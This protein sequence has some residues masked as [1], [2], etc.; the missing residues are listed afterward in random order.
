MSSSIGSRPVITSLVKRST[1]SAS[2]MMLARSSFGSALPAVPQAERA[3]LEG[4]IEGYPNKVIA[5]ELDISPRTV[6][7]HRSKVMEKLEVR[8]LSEA[9]RI[10]FAAGL[11]PV[12]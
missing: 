11:I 1:H 3:V 6:E 5:H 12:A 9:L 10:S 4:L 7:I 2:E 8:S